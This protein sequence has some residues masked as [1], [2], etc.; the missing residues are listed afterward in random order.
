MSSSAL[1]IAVSALRAQ[2]YVIE[3]TSQNVANAATP[4]YRR[5]RVDLTEAFPR[6]GAL[7][8]MGAG[9]EASSITRATDQLADLRVRGS[10]AQA[11]YFGV[12]GTVMKQAEDIYGEP[13]QG[14]TKELSNTWDAF[15]ALAVSPS[16]D[17]SRYQ[18]LSALNGV[19]A[20]VNQVRTG[21]DQLKSDAN[22]QLTTA[23]SDANALTS[24]LAQI[25]KF[26]RVPGGLPATLADERDMDLDKLASALG[27]TAEVTA[28]GR[29]RVSI[30]G[31]AV[32]DEELSIPLSVSATTPGQIM[33]P[34]G[35]VTIG[36]TAGGLATS[37]TTDIADARSQL[38]TFVTGLVSAINAAHAT[39]FTPAG[40]PG[41]ALLAD[42]GGQLTVLATQPG[43]LAAT[44]TAGQTLNGKVADAMAQLRDTQGAAFRTVTSGLSGAVAGIGQS[45]DTAQS[46]SDAAST[47]RD[48]IVGVNMDEEMANLVTQQR[49]YDAAAR[50]VK[51]VDEMLQTLVGMTA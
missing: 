4:G 5:E 8:P 7:G 27:A 31:L 6:Q 33:N 40:A 12:R 46:I 26:A 23:I 50:L 39:G 20:R 21:L 45:A 1:S 22:Q 32:V 30:N 51:V 42:S 17:A 37:I 11:S 43:D 2:Q 18:V 36:G 16:D 41:G 48:S 9:V 28:D 15:S 14:I 25:N 3:T 34:T 47:Q 13:D 29:A 49:A 19:A 24:R 35:P 10:S 38:D 44:D